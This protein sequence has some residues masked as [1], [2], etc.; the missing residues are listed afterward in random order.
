MSNLIHNLEEGVTNTVEFTGDVVNEFVNT[1]LNTVGGVLDGVSTLTTTTADI[2][3]TVVHDV[4]GVRTSQFFDGVGD[5]SHQVSEKLGDIIAEVP[6]VGGPVAYVVKRGGDGVYHVVVSVGSLVETST[7]RVSDAVRQTAGLVVF[8]LTAGKDQLL[9][10]GRRVTE[11]V[12]TLLKRTR[13]SRTH[14][15]NGE[16]T[17]M[18]RKTTKKSAG[19]RRTK[20]RRNT[21]Q[22]GGRTV[23]PNEYFGG[24]SGAYTAPAGRMNPAFDTAYGQCNP[25]SFG[26]SGETPGFH[27]P[28][29]MAPEG[30]YSTNEASALPVGGRRQTVMK[31][32]QRKTRLKQKPRR[33]SSSN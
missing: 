14:L 9:E 17:S 16:N 4:V 10:V 19:S 8:T 32:Q 23:L 22:T 2:F 21:V 7:R 18:S 27:G 25:T 15:V 3:N 26:S 11:T 24:D 30:T 31:T 5:I 13:P 1:V 28:F 6:L 29:S 20:R 12:S 33:R